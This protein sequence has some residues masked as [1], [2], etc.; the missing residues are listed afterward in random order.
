MHLPKGAEECPGAL[1]ES[2]DGQVERL[3][4]HRPVKGLRELSSGWT[5]L[6]MP[7][8]TQDLSHVRRELEE[9]KRS[10]LWPMR[11]EAN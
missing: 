11:T 3:I 2:H 5:Q 9:V 6:G 4:S 7:I 1:T 8:R 10:C